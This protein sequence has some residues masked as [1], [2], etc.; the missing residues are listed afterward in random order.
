MLELMVVL[1]T[2][3][4]LS[5]LSMGKIAD[6]IA[7]QRVTKAAAAIT[8][9]LQ[10][11]FAIAGRNRRPVRI[12]IDTAKMQLNITDRGQTTSFRRI[13]L[14]EVY[15]LRAAN[16]RFYPSTPIEVFPN[17][18]SSDTLSITLSANGST[19]RLRVT[20]AGMV[21]IRTS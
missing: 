16:V 10:Q 3:G 6:V 9:D 8:N 13:S 14:R 1:V 5:G 7:Q 2:A 20:R 21:Q 19:R 4:I 11:A 15:N 12:V 17:G 18:L